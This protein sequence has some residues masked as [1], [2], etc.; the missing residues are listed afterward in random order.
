M[1][2]LL[3]HAFRVGLPIIMV[4][5]VVWTIGSVYLEDRRR[6]RI[7]RGRMLAATGPLVDEESPVTNAKRIGLYARKRSGVAPTLVWWGR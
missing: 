5:G 3:E 4:V 6:R 1:R 7:L 2:D